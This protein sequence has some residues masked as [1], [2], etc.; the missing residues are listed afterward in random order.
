V[1]GLPEYL[2]LDHDLGIVRG[3]LSDSTHLLRW[4]LEVDELA[5]TVP[6]PAYT[7]HSANPSGAATLRS[8]MRSWRKLYEMN[9][10]SR[11]P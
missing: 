4:L 3:E 8:L 11:N 1:R 5:S 2:W 6:P 7:V 10:P 9:Q